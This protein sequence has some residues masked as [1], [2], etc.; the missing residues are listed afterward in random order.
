[1]Q[2]KW[3]KDLETNLDK[4]LDSLQRDVYKFNPVKKG[5]TSNGALVIESKAGLKEFFQFKEVA[6]KL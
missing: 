6:M 5:I 1:M 3:I 4:F 2:H